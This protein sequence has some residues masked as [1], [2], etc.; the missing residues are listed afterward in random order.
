MK[1]FVAI[2]LCIVMMFSLCGCSLTEVGFSLLGQLMSIFNSFD[3]DGLHLFGGVGVTIKN[4]GSTSTLIPLPES[5][6]FAGY[7]ELKY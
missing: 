5:I 7:S 3:L 2:L 1:K 6:R 4:D